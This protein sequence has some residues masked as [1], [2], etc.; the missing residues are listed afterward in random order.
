[1]VTTTVREQFNAITAFVDAS[2]VYGSDDDT[3]GALRAN[4]GGLLREARGGYLPHTQDDA[5]NVLAA[6]EKRALV[7]PGLLS[8]HTLFLREHNRI[9]KELANLGMDD[10]ETI[11]QEARRIVGAEMQNIAFGEYLEALGI[12]SMLPDDGE[13]S[14]YHP[15]MDP[16]IRND[17]ATAVFRFGHSMVEGTIRLQRHSLAS[18]SPPDYDIGDNFKD[19]DCS[20][21]KHNF[22]EIL[23]SFS[24]MCSRAC[25]LSLVSDVR[26]KLFLNVAERKGLLDDGDESIEMPDLAARNIERGREHG[27][28][29]YNEYRRLCGLQPSC[30][31]SERPHH[32]SEATWIKLQ[33]IYQDP[34]DVDLFTAG[35]AETPESGS[36]LGPTF[37]CLFK[38]QFASLMM[39]D[40]YF[41]THH[42]D[43]H[44]NPFNDDQLVNIKRRTLSDVMCDNLPLSELPESAFLR[45]SPPRACSLNNRIDFGL[46][47]DDGGLDLGGRSAHRTVVKVGDLH[48]V[49]HICKDDNI[50][51]DRHAKF[52]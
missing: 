32:I 36:V 1:M 16:S 51:C 8:F 15:E 45:D 12:P 27:L 29:G 23:F 24:K 50:D 14:D 20:R 30:S 18:T 37:A 13:R 22:V 49:E 38:S 42:P 7:V 5:E 39:G 2:N 40:R 35:L 11:Y 9:A 31:W 44:P 47:V 48:N 4:V 26:D 3:A 46:F 25:D 41:F 19:P 52:R 17:F 43:T 21:Y 6:G 34:D 33:R 28:P 10:D